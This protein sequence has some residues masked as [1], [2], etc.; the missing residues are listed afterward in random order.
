MNQNGGRP[1]GIPGGRP[2]S[3]P[4][5]HR[6]PEEPHEPLRGLDQPELVGPAQAVED[7]RPAVVADHAAVG[8]HETRRDGGRQERIGISIGAGQGSPGQEGALAGR[9]GRSRDE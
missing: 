2:A 3:R 6:L 5:E 1:G 4:P 7:E 8:I 9:S